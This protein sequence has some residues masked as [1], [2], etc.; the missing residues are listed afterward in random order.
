MSPDS[1]GTQVWTTARG[2][3]GQFTTPSFSLFWAYVLGAALIAALVHVVR[4][5]SVIG[6]LRF[7]AP[8]EVWLRRSSLNDLALFVLNT[9]LYSFWLLAPLS[10][11]GQTLASKTWLALHHSCGPIGAP[12]SGP[13]AAL[14]LSITLFV[15][16]DL[17][18]FLGHLAMH[19]IPLLW[20]FHKVHHSAPVLQPVTVLRR[21]PVSIVVDGA[22]TGL[23]LGP[24]YGLAGWLGGG[25][26]QPWTIAGVNGLLVLGLLAGFNLQHSHVWL[27][28]GIL[29][30]VLIS[31]ATHQ[32]H[33]SA[34]PAHHNR[35]FGNF[36]AI[37]DRAA[38]SLLVPREAVEPGEP[39][40]LRFGLGDPGEAWERDYRSVWRLYLWPFW[41]VLVRARELWTRRLG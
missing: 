35:N 22:I 16:A 21:H 34:D 20:E 3:A 4:R 38:G 31:P 11:I 6:L 39:A 25:Q 10:V 33:H 24:V 19:R 28:F 12:L 41:R 5:R 37:W 17:G 8:R 7:L 30:R 14:G 13:A 32:L 26:L 27:S 40:Q 29:D 9:L 2:V 18:F 36:L 15:V 23:V 1:W